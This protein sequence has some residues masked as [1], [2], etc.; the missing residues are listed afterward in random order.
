MEPILAE[1]KKI[2]RDLKMRTNH[3]N[4]LDCRE[5]IHIQLTPPSG[6][7]E[8]VAEKTIF[9]ITT[10]DQSHSPVWAQ[11]HD[12]ARQ[13]VKDLSSTFTRLSHGMELDEFISML[14]REKPDINPETE[15]TVYY[16]RKVDSPE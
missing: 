3:N 7:P 14:I 1:K 16:Y 13:T 2:I 5:F 8:S 6:I 12:S 4:K 15:L 10:A 11:I 9:K